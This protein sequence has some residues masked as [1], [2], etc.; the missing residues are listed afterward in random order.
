[1]IVGEDGKLDR[2]VRDADGSRSLAA[3]VDERSAASP[4]G[5]AR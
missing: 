4:N 1:M 5:T 2:D 3:R